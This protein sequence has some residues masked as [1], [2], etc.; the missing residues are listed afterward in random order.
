MQIL[1]FMKEPV[2]FIPSTIISNVRE[3]RQIII[4]CEQNIIRIL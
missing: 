1:V 2:N 4:E 3:P